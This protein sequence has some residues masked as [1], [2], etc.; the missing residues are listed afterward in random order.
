MLMVTHASYLGKRSR[1]SDTRAY[2]ININSSKNTTYKVYLIWLA[3]G[4]RIQ[5]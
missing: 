3:A 2:V 5:A 1:P 4:Q